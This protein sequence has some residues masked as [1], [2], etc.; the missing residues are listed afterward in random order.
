MLNGWVLSILWGWFFV[1]TLSLPALGV[2]QA[3]GVALVA[4][5]L[6]H[7]RQKT[8]GEENVGEALRY[9]IARP[10]VALGVGFIVKHFM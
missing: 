8:S 9:E 6:T 1:P 10:I 4:S 7:Q 3:I 5:Y 2:A